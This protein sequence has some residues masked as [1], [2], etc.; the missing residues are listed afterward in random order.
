MKR[1]AVLIMLIFLTFGCASYQRTEVKMN[2]DIVYGTPKDIEVF[3]ECETSVR[4]WLVNAGIMKSKDQSINILFVKDVASKTKM[5]IA[6][7]SIIIGLYL[8][9]QDKIYVISYHSRGKLRKFNASK[10][11]LY[12]AVIAHEIGH[13]Y[14]YHLEYPY[15]RKAIQEFLCATIEID[16]LSDKVKKNILK[17]AEKLNRSEIVTKEYFLDLRN[18]YRSYSKYQK[19]SYYY[20]VVVFDRDIE[21]F[22]DYFGRNMWIKI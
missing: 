8:R 2:N 19:L 17:Q 7:G 22:K 14:L 9:D 13:A 10:K 6:S 21:K 1:I 3:Q 18:Y 20:W 15:T 4:N 5:K 12:K 11:S 16:L